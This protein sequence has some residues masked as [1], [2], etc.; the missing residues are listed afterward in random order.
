MT[1]R[2]H[3][4]RGISTLQAARVAWDR[5]CAFS[6]VGRR[7]PWLAAIF[8]PWMWAFH[9]AAVGQQGDQIRSFRGASLSV[10]D[11]GLIEQAA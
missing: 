5:T 2:G 3:V 11:G 1:D 10:D 6:L 7:F 8:A 4:S 9:L